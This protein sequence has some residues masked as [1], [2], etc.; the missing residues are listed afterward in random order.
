M[1][2][3]LPCQEAIHL[4]IHVATSEM[5]HFPAGLE[6]LLQTAVGFFYKMS[7]HSSVFYYKLPRH[8][9]HLRRHPVKN[10]FVKL[11][12]LFFMLM[13]HQKQHPHIHGD[14]Y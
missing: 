9:A 11:A 10:P 14:Y 5:Q 1:C 6:Q 4:A 12:M 2:L 13:R 7:R 8:Q 3:C